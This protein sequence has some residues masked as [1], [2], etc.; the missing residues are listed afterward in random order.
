MKTRRNREREQYI[1]K[2]FGGMLLSLFLFL[3]MTSFSVKGTETTM[4]KAIPELGLENGIYTIGADFSGGLI[5]TALTSPVRM[6]I[7]DGTM[8]ALV[9]WESDTYEYMIVDGVKYLPEDREGNSKF[10]IPVSGTDCEI[11]VTIGRQDLGISAKA[12]GTILF[13][14]ATIQKAARVDSSYAMASAGIS[15]SGIIILTTLVL[16]FLHKRMK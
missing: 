8:K 16:V 5:G 9:E 7:K 14:S 6:Q 12:D 4:G 3:S 10:K 1:R 11:P 2:A 15:F 13:H